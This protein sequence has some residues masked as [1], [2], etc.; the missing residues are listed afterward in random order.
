MSD[1]KQEAIGFFIGR[2]FFLIIAVLF[3]LYGLFL[4]QPCDID[5]VFLSCRLTGTV[6]D[7][8][9]GAMFFSGLVWLSGIV[10]GVRNL[11]NP[12]GSSQWN[13]IT[14]AGLVL[15]VVIFWNL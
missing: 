3:L 13:L 5:A 4:K 11:Y 8:I 9:G 6:G 1:K 12:P 14:A 10:K 7:W 15:S 2:L